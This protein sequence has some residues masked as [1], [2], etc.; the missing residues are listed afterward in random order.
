[1]SV[2]L[3]QVL[4]VLNHVGI[5]NMCY[6]HHITIFIY[7]N[8]HGQDVNKWCSHNYGKN[9]APESG[10]GWFVLP[11]T[12]RTWFRA[13]RALKCSKTIKKYITQEFYH[14]WYSPP[15]ASG[16]VRFLNST[17]QSI[18]IL[19]SLLWVRPAVS[20]HSALS[21]TDLSRPLLL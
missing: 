9:C 21:S 20:R 1:M 15:R 2:Y 18:F 5:F 13:W 3:T 7:F 12:S 19:L 8:V 4:L 10:M 6:L 11:A 14:F 17:I 16:V